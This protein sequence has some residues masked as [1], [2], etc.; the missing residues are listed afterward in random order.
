[1]IA[2]ALRIWREPAVH[3]GKLAVLAALYLVLAKG[4]L[5]LA[6][7]HPSASP[8]WAPSGLALAAVL[9]W[10]FGVWP[11]IF[12]GAFLANLEQAGALASAMIAAGNT[13]E[14][15]ITGW[16]VRRWA[17]GTRAFDS[18]WGVAIFA[19]LCVA[20]GTLVSATVGVGS[21]AMSGRADPA[22]IL[23][24]W[25]T[26][27]LG[28][29]GGQLLVAPA[30]VLWL[31]L[32]QP[33][34]R[35]EFAR[36]V[37]VYAAA[38]LVGLIAFS[39]AVAQTGLRG[40]LAFLAI[41]PLL[42][43]A[44]LHGPRVTASA[45]LLLFGFAV[46]G[47]AEGGGPFARSEV[48][49]SFLLL[50]SFGISTVV[51]SLVLSADA[52]SRARIE[53]LLRLAVRRVDLRVKRRTAALG[54]SNRKLMLEVEG[55]ARLEAQLLGAQRLANLGSWSWDVA[56]ARVI[57]SD[58]LLSIYGIG[59]EEFGGTFDDFLARLHPEDRPRIEAAVKEAFNCGNGFR[60]DERI[61][62]PDGEIRF[63]QSTGQVIRGA[64]GSAVQMIGICQDVTDHKRAQ[65]ALDAARE[66]LAQSQKME[67]IG[68]LT[69]GVAHDF[70]NLLTIII[71]NL[72]RMLRRLERPNADTARLAD[73]ARNALHGA[74]RAAALTR[75]LLAFS[76][77]QPLDAETIDVNAVV[78]NMS[79][80]LR[81]SL[82]ER[83]EV[84]ARLAEDT[85]LAYAD[86]NQL[87]G[88]ILNLAVNARDA[89]PQG[90][91]LAIETS[92]SRNGDLPSDNAAGTYVVIRVRDTGSGMSLE[93]AARAFE[94]FFTTKDIG[95]GT[96]LG[97]SQVYGFVKQSGG[98]VTI[99][100]KPGEGTVVTLYLSVAPAA[101]VES[102][103][104]VQD[105]PPRVGAGETIL[106]VEDDPDVRAHS[107]EILQ[108]LGYA[109]LE[110]PDAKHGLAILERTP[111]ISLLFS[112]VGLPGGMNGRQLASEALRL[113]P[114]LKVLLATGYAGN[115]IAQGEKLP[116]GIEIIAKPF[117]FEALGSKLT[118]MLREAR[119][120]VLIVE[121]EALLRLS[122]V[123]DLQTLGFEVQEAASAAQALA[124]LDGIC[125]AIVDVGLPDMKGDA[126]AAEIRAR[127]KTLPLIIASG[128]REAQILER[129]GADRLIRF[130]SKPYNLAQIEAALREVGVS[131]ST[132]V[133]AE[134]A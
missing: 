88:A 14:A 106:V 86:R 53:R 125:A 130:L 129:F 126:L 15:C 3:V 67:S 55:R 69:G 9:L 111:A 31:R 49:E 57:W 60:H 83:I 100:S 115:A 62:R 27:W 45:A 114:S 72:E 47:A 93:T 74:E 81:R 61:V 46:W 34:R 76:R 131:E 68:Q 118:S 116:S 44:L 121:D 75:Q 56:S 25:T 39:P 33:P 85:R 37:P 64:N 71:G 35:E 16:L 10:G 17:S 70:N 20:T 18:P 5:A 6:S 127:N 84:I 41:V 99:E 102:K 107:V 30:I 28:D 19:A 110:A 117:A 89:M 2:E 42:W 133:Q 63:L 22:A 98:H 77:R 103:P 79:D 54:E 66:Q 124:H 1:M 11:A 73:A 120:R 50:L 58:Q 128:Y 132:P 104:A 113:R 96:G 92:N 95:H 26:W 38:V 109:T 12:T 119:P 134:G 80:M 59:R 90:G 97:L 105:I 122:V 24:I 51:P 108:E 21:L 8:I 23:G 13:L 123:E 82:G 43:A 4:G 112:D 65:S 48:N 7:V 101:E 29:V 78:T 94:P 52:A 40:P 87:E 36:A 91:Q 32:R